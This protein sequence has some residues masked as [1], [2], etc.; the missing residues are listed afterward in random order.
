MGRCWGVGWG[1]VKQ[2][3]AIIVVLES[4]VHP[5]LSERQYGAVFLP[6]FNIQFNW[7]AFENHVK[8]KEFCW[9]LQFLIGTW[10]M[11]LSCN[12]PLVVVSHSQLFYYLPKLRQQSEIFESTYI[13]IN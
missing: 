2:L 4:I 6:N 12:I 1:G 10:V 8:K 7:L 3:T 13:Y 11:N 9:L 5:F